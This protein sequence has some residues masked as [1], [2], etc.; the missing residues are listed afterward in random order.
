[1]HKECFSE[2][3]WKVLYVLKDM[4][5]KYNAI[6]A[7]GTALALHLGHRISLDLDFFTNKD[8]KVESIISGIRKT[9]YPFRVISEGEEH[10]IADVDGIKVS[11]FKYDYPFTDSPAIYK[12]IKIAGLLDIAS[13]KVIAICQ[14]GTKR[15]FVDL[16]FI[17]R[18][19]PFHRMAEHMVKRFGR[20]RI[21]PVHIGKSLV[22]FS[23]ADAD[24]E[25]VYIKGRELKWETVKKFFRSHVKQFVLD[26]DGAVKES[27][28]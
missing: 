24:P 23:D 1:M 22:Y 9:G 26:I 2:K 18:D 25:P 20:E 13:M 8:F 16:Y 3:G 12:G 15:D 4:L 21:N 19:M 27:L 7:G 17:L 14:R 11:F 10:L 6:L 5:T 28:P